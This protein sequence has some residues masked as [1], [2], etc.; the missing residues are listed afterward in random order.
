MSRQQTLPLGIAVLLFMLFLV[1]CGSTAPTSVS[2][3]P[4]ATSTPE[5]PAATPTPI[6]PTPTPTPIPSTPTLTPVSSTPTPSIPAGTIQGT[7]IN[8]ATGKPLSGDLA[9]LLAW[10]AEQDPSGGEIT[11]LEAPFIGGN[12]FLQ[13]IVD[14]K[15][16]F[17]LSDIP[18]DKY[19]LILF[20]GRPDP[21]NPPGPY[22]LRDESGQKLIADLTQ[23]EGVDLGEILVPIE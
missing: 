21:A 20:V 3:A 16:A 14:E 5:S 23:G 11:N 4:A 15:G 12:P 7:L 13:I 10:E 18:E 19:L 22:L 9:L 17:T 1:G 6:P 2:E 8:A